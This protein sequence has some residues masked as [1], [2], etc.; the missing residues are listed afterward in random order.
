MFSH[1]DP[2]LR[3]KNILERYQNEFTIVEHGPER[4]AIFIQGER[5]HCGIRLQIN[6]PRSPPA[7]Y[8][9]KQYEA[10]RGSTGYFCLADKKEFSEETAR[11]SDF[12]Q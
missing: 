5:A 11:I 9:I 10:M 4:L 2:D 3:S 12:F 8:I 1:A 6:A 7:G